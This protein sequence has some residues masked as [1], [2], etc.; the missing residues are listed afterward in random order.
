MLTVTNNT[1]IHVYMVGVCYE[2]KFKTTD[3]CVKVSTD[4][5][6]IGYKTMVKNKKH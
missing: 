3:E 2:H 5:G 1:Y 4:I 6:T